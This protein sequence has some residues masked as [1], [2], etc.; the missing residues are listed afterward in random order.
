MGY[1][2]GIHNMIVFDKPTT[3]YKF[4]KKFSGINSEVHTECPKKVQIILSDDADLDELL[5][6]FQDFLIACGFALAEDEKLVIIKETENNEENE[7]DSNL[8]L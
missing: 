3:T 1:N 6:T 2:S 4:T 7:N 5:E 8:D